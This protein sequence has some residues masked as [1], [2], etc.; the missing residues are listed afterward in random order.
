MYEKG[1]KMGI[2]QL[3]KSKNF[4]I[5]SLSAKAGIPYSTLN[6]FVN[7]KTSIYKMQFGYVKKISEALWVTIEELE[8]IAE[9]EKIFSKYGEIIVKNKCYYLKCPL[10]EEPSYLCKVNSFNKDYV[11]TLAEWEYEYLQKCEIEKQW[12]N[13]ALPMN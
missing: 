4:N 5:K 10:K 2:K 7:G 9:E 6:D 8:K 13:N 3:I 1:L 12:I 11:Q